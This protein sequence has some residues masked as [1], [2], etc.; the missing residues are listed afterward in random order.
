MVVKTIIKLKA[1]SKTAYVTP[2]KVWIPYIKGINGLP[3]ISFTTNSIRDKTTSKKKGL[4]WTDSRAL[5]DI[6]NFSKW[7][8]DGTPS[9][10]NHNVSA[11]FVF[12]G[13]KEDINN[14]RG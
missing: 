10:R 13:T 12:N 1:S 9:A 3:T 6:E 14:F 2:E 11:R 4:S 5:L 8:T 7:D